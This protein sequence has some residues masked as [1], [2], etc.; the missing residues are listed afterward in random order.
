MAVALAV[1]VFSAHAADAARVKE[2]VAQQGCLGC[3]AMTMRLVGPS[4]NEVAAR[5]RMDDL[6][7]LVVRIQSG[8]SGKWGNLEM[9]P[10]SNLSL[11][12]ARLLAEWVL[13]SGP[14]K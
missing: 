8:G 6:N 11:D 9:P 5:Y 3:H 14:A 4:F 2:L 10:Q 7:G 1:G 13:S 12:D